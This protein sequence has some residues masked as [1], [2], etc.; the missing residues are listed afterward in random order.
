MASVATC[1]TPSPGAAVATYQFGTP[2]EALINDVVITQD[3]AWLTDSAQVTLCFVPIDPT[4]PP[5][6]FSALALTGPAAGT[7]GE[8]NLTGIAATPDGD[9]LIVAHST[10]EALYTVDPV[11]GANAWTRSPGYGRAQT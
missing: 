11:T 1:S 8:F 3:G 5:G 9:T 7:G 2:G 10:S 4:G 6:T